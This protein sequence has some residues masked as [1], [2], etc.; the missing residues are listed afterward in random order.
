VTEADNIGP[1]LIRRHIGRRLEALRKHAGLT[2]RKA[3]AMV[4]L[5]ESTIVRMEDG[6]DNVRF[7]DVQ[8]RHMLEVY[9]A[10]EDEREVLLALT[11]ETRAPRTT[12]WWHNYTKT[13]L[14]QWFQVYVQ[15][16]DSAETI[17]LY[18]VELVP[19]LLQ[20]YEYAS[21]IMSV[22]PGRLDEEERRRRVEVR[23]ERQSLLTR[24]RAPKIHVALSEAAISRVIGMGVDVAREQ[25]QHLLDVTQKANIVLQ[26][27]P[28]SA[29]VHAG[30]T[31]G[32]GFNIL[33]FPPNPGGGEP[34]EPPL[35][36]V[37]SLTGAMYLTEP[38]EVNSYE[39]IWDDLLQRALDPE[40]SREIITSALK[41]LLP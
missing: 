15:L 38:P 2:I 22:P 14:P 24:A 4:E 27:I 16:E 9:G 23:M 5:S 26:V 36:Y 7:R 1:A 8:V 17:R 12:S 20:T 13:S 3:S 31:A 41:G 18:Q 6:A 21:K 39:Q 33:D 40:T 30:M 29:G 34:I 32:A 19:G 25:L 35:A 37:E 10:S 11:A 28:W